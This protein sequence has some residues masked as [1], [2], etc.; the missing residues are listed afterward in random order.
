[1][2]RYFCVKIKFYLYQLTKPHSQYVVFI[3]NRGNDLIPTSEQSFFITKF[4]H[5]TNNP[6]KIVEL[7]GH[8]HLGSVLHY[9]EY[10]KAKE[11]VSG[12]HMPNGVSTSPDGK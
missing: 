7:F 8:V 6:L 12:L 10:T 11:V 3:T 4:H 5:F 1:M 2:Y 9:N